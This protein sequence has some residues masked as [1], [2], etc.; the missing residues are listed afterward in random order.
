M[1]TA[2]LSTIAK[3]WKQP[4]RPPTDE[5]TNKMWDIHTTGYYP[6]TKWNEVQI[7][8]MIQVNPESVMLREKS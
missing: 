8:A 3:K 5:W 4:Q 1:L 6:E 7:H 2:A